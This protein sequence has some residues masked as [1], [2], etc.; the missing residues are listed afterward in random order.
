M[1]FSPLFWVLA[2]PGLVLGLWAQARVR[3]NF[4]KY[5]KIR[6]TRNLTGAEVARSLLDAYGLYDVGV[7]E[8]RGMLSD[9]YDPRAKVLRLSEGVY[10]SNS[11]AA[12]GIAAHEMGHALQDAKNYGPLNL[13]SALVPATQFGTNLAPWIFM[14]G[15]FLS[16][17]VGQVGLMIAWIGVG[18]FALAVLFSLVTLP[19]EFDATKRAKELLVRENILFNDEMK[20]VNAVL[21]AAAWTYVAAA[22]SAIGTLLYYVMLLAGGR[23]Q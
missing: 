19:V 2:L 4:N 13:R 21:D 12:A 15:Y 14:G 10:R 5:A 23:R 22:V 11:V 1:F 18:L 20:G 17:L 7:E 16:T 6:T 3:S 8:T 9:H